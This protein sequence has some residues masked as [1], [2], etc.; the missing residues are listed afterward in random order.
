[1][2]LLLYENAILE[3]ILIMTTNRSGGSSARHRY[4]NAISL[5]DSAQVILLFYASTYAHP[6]DSLGSYIVSLLVSEHD[7]KIDPDETLQIDEDMKESLIELLQEHCM[8]DESKAEQVL[9]EIYALVQTGVLPAPFERRHD[10]EGEISMPTDKLD[11]LSPSVL[12]PNDL[13]GEE[14]RREANPFAVSGADS[15]NEAK[16]SKDVSPNRRGLPTLSVPDASDHQIKY[17]DEPQYY[18]Q[19]FGYEQYEYDSQQQEQQQHYN[20]DDCV[21]IL[22]AY[23]SHLPLSRSAA[24]DASTVAQNI[25]AHA[26]YLIEAAIAAPPVC[27]HLL[28]EGCYLKDCTYSHVIGA[29]LFW[30]KGLCRLSNANA[31]TKNNQ[32][33]FHHHFDRRVLDDMLEEMERQERLDG[34]GGNGCYST[35]YEHSHPPLN[36][37]DG[38]ALQKQT[39]TTSFAEIATL[40]YSRAAFAN[41]KS[42]NTSASQSKQQQHRIIPTVP[43]PRDL[44]NPHENRDA[45][46]FYIDDPMERYRHVA[47]TCSRGDVIDLHYQSISTFPVVLESILSYKLETM[48][49]VWIVTGTGHHVGSNTHQKGGGA[50]ESAVTEW[51]IYEGYTFAKGR[52][53]NGQGGA[54]LVQR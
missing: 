47:K 34:A 16:S 3:A 26:Q 44:W 7:N 14:N 51:L 17:D 6:D 31:S 50:L 49:K 45:T 5:D 4:A 8:I 9:Q 35:P 33:P 27:R 41:S 24:V 11:P 46:V 29:C 52:D 25:P 36:E 22:L 23:N 54:I 43:I 18:Q 32:C 12:L 39:T 13:L 15:F 10:D 48:D 38:N 40:G 30:I 19:E 42:S 21:E 28:N 20:L 1:M 53:R 37:S 2:H